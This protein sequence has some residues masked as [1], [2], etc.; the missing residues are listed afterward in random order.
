MY[1]S[2]YNYNIQYTANTFTRFIPNH[3]SNEIT[4]NLEI[5]ELGRGAFGKVM[6]ISKD[7]NNYALKKIN[8]AE[9]TMEEIETYKN[10][11]KILSSFS[12]FNNDYIIKYYNSYE[13]NNYLNII[14]EYGGDCDLKK[15]IKKYKD[16]N[17]L[18]DEAILK[19]IISQICM[20]LEEIHKANI[21]HRD[22][23]PENIFINEN[24]DIKI[25]DFGISKKLGTNKN[26]T[27][28]ENGK[29]TFGYMAPEIVQGGKITK[30]VDIY[31]LG[32]II[33]ELFHLSRYHDDKM[34]NGIKIIDYE[35]YN[36]KWQ[37]LIDLL[38]KTESNERPNIEEI[39][40]MIVL[41]DVN[42]MDDLKELIKLFVGIFSFK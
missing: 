34:W 20:G 15:F 36:E 9:L 40:Q 21:I 18:I 10:E 28:T 8:I 31:S 33:Y 39:I 25:G 22:L 7:N 11:I 16:R 12:N 32:C 14:M 3:K 38:L 17:Q 13:E 1:Y 4:Q 26:S 24:N 5:K 29:G 30:K 27:Y 23:K 19:K 41:F 37:K 42:S 35:I 6:L 2:I